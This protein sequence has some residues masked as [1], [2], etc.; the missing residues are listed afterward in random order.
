MQAQVHPDRMQGSV[1]ASWSS[2]INR[3]NETLRNPLQRA[4]YL[5][6]LHER[7]SI[8]DDE[9]IINAS[10]DV[11]DI[12]LVLEVRESIADSSDN[13]SVLAEL[14]RENDVRIA[15]CCKELEELLDNGNTDYG[16]VKRCINRLRYWMGVEEELK[17]LIE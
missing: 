15:D 11:H 5:V 7:E 6:N 8:R 17:R 1:G 9:E 13:P 12:S 3:A 16:A 14:K 4:I 10:S 2:W